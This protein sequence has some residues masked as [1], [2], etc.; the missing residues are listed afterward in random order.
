M[1]LQ[2]T[3]PDRKPLHETEVLFL[4][5]LFNGLQMSFNSTHMSW[6]TLHLQIRF[7][8]CVSLLGCQICLEVAKKNKKVKKKILSLSTYLMLSG[9][10]Q[11]NKWGKKTTSK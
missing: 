3:G 1:S 6:L 8:V 10:P 7:A 2:Q 9:V 4:N 5:G 11:E